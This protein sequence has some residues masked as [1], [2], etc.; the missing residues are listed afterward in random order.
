MNEFLET[1]CILNGIPQHLEWHQRRIDSTFHFCMSHATPF[2]L[3]SALTLYDLPGQGKIKCSVHY[4]TEIIDVTFA[5]YSPKI[6]QHL[7]L[8]EIPSDYDYRFKFA[9]RR[10]IEDLFSKRDTSDDILMTRSG[11]ITDT[12]IANI[13]FRKN[14]RWYTP[15][16]PLLA[17]TT[18]K[19][20]IAE[21]IL[22]P[23]PIHQSELDQLDGFKIFNAMNDWGKVEEVEINHRIT[24]DGS[25][26]TIR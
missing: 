23:R 21:E 11:W 26:F 18:W 14:D 5:P 3:V 20:L 24:G 25:R 22:I 17:G 13:A 6:V 10:V 12:S 1:I 2:Q 16:N 19:R 7:R 9:D 4:A 8:I 15:S